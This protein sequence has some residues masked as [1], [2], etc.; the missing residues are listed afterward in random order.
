MVCV[1]GG[2]CLCV[3]FVFLCVACVNVF[4]CV[5]SGLLCRV[6]QS[7]VCAVLCL[8]V[9]C[10]FVCVVCVIYCAMSYGLFFVVCMCLC[11]FV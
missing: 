11:V 1:F 3:W 2:L 8:R 5:V 7:V 6:V 9:S 10:L 4:A